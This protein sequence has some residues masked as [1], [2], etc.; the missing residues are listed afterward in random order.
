M[1]RFALTIAALSIVAGCQVYAQPGRTTSNPPPP[2]A[3]APDSSGG[4]GA[5]VT[6]PNPGCS[7]PGN[8]CLPGGPLYFVGKKAWDGNYGMLSIGV[9]QSPPDGAGEAKFFLKKDGSEVVSKWF[10][11][12]QKAD[13]AQL[14]VGQMA[15]MFHDNR[16][17]QGYQAPEVDQDA[18]SKRWWI[19]RIVSLTPVATTN[20]V[21]VSGGYK[22]SVDNIRHV[23]GDQHETVVVGGTEDPHFLTEDYWLVAKRPLKDKGYQM[24]QL[25]AAIAPPSPSTKN[26]GHFMDIRSG[27]QVWSGNAWRTRPATSDEIKLGARVYMF[28]D[29]RQSSGYSKPASRHDA[30]TSRW[31]TG[32]VT[33]TSTAYKGTVTVAGRYQV[34]VDNLR[35]ALP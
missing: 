20:H 11:S 6:A 8:H 2:L 26:E 29:N 27:K 13:P 3:E 7:T 30:L 18:V 17:S 32:R 14:K 33:D 1:H 31:W 19:A 15:V 28:H 9:Q 22:V 34:A 10:H 21:I 23:D 4:R 16:Q 12:T 25:S 24:L 35:V 5:G